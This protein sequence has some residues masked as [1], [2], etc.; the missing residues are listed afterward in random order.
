MTSTAIC[1]MI[2]T[3]VVVCGGFVASIVRLQM[4]SSKQS[5]EEE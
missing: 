4:I 3:L 5:K 2:F 1:M